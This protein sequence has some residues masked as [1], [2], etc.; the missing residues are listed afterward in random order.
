MKRVVMLMGLCIVVAACA[1]RKAG[2]ETGKATTTASAEEIAEWVNSGNEAWANRGEVDQLRKALEWWEKALAADPNN[3]EVLTSL[4]RGYY[5]LADGF[6]EDNE[7]KIE[8]HD[9]G[10]K[11]GERALYTNAEL[12]RAIDAGGKLEDNV[13]KLG[14]EF[15]GAMYWTASN[16]GKY[17]V[18]KGIM[19]NLFLLPRVKA[20]N[21]RVMELDEGYYYAGPHRFFGAFYAKAPAFAG[22]DMEKSVKH[23]EKA[24]ELAP[25]YFGTRVLYAEYYAAKAGKKDLFKKQLDKV[26]MAAVDV[27]PDIVPEQTIEK[28]KAEKLL[29]EE[30]ELFN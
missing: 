17:G 26:N 14:E 18:A 3:V 15:I 30:D 28:A 6:T 4:C 1:G 21:S 23:F 25:D 11:Y 8:L 24:L 5:F 29:A 16:N 22:G 27:L 12:K 10:A 20:L 13:D 7:K 2:F 9:K 19:Q